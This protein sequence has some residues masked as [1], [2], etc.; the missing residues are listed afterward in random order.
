MALRSIL[1]DEAAPPI[2]VEAPAYFADLLLDQVV[3][4]ITDGRG[5]YD[6]K[7]FFCAPLQ[8]VDAVAYR[9]EVFRD[10]EREDLARCVGAFAEGMRTL[11]RPNEKKRSWTRRI[12]PGRDKSAYTFQIADRDEA[13]ARALSEL[14]ARG[15][16]LV[17]NALAQST[18]HVLSFFG[19]LRFELGFYVAC[20]NLHERLAAKGEPVCFPVPAASSDAAL[21]AAGLYDAC[22]SLSVDERVVGNELAADGKALVMITGANRAARRRSCAPWGWPT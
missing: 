14:R 18:D 16:N 8:S 11:R 2:R 12:S 7:P 6:L 3:E 19:V 22:L 10:L 20:L 13:G 1:S 9:H 21:S 4:S 15:I 17:A 5:E